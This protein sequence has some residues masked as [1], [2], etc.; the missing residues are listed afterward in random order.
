[1]TKRKTIFTSHPDCVAIGKVISNNRMNLSLSH[2]GRQAFINDRVDLGLLPEGWLSVKSLANI[3]NGYNLPSLS[4]LY[5]LSVATEID[6]P[7][8]IQQLEPYL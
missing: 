2:P 4:T 8:L 7:K 3:E 6:F 5:E 1:M